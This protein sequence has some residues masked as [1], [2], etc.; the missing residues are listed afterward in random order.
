M[1]H[2]LRRLHEQGARLHWAPDRQHLRDDGRGL[3]VH[4]G[5]HGH[6]RRPLAECR[7]AVRDPAP[8]RRGADPVGIHGA[9]LRDALRHHAAERLRLH[10]DHRA[11]QRDLLPRARAA[12]HEL[13]PDFPPDP[14]VGHRRVRHRDVVHG[15][16]GLDADDRA[17][18]RQRGRRGLP[19]GVRLHDAGLPALSRRGQAHDRGGAWP[20]RVRPVPAHA[21]GRVLPVRDDA[22]RGAAD[23]E[24]VRRRLP[25]RLQREPTRTRSA[26]ATRSCCRPSRRCPRRSSS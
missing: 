19:G 11:Q 20:G 6:R 17:A 14:R 24:R 26:S 15:P 12:G 8:R 4:A 13:H 21:D 16:L 10:A 25:D 22:G 7:A 5:P 18:L 3:A 1:A 9:R 2:F 23:H